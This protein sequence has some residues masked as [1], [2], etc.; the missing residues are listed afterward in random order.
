[1]EWLWYI[2]DFTI[3]YFI[4]ALFFISIVNK[5]YIYNNIKNIFGLSFEAVPAIREFSK[6]KKIII[7]LLIFISIIVFIKFLFYNKSAF[8]ILPFLIIAADIYI[9]G[10]LQGDYFSIHQ[11]IL[12]YNDSIVCIN[13]KNP[14][15]RFTVLKWEDIQSIEYIENS[16]TVYQFVILLKSCKEIKNI[17]LYKHN[18]NLYL[19]LFNKYKVNIA[20]G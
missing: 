1:M 8:L 11:T 5:F 18:L 3:T 13:P 2:W 10:K 16:K 9:S 19:K 17:I 15:K 4:W 7:A 12:Y 20:N 14:L 6:T